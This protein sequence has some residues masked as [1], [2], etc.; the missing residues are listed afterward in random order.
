MNGDYIE[1]KIGKLFNLGYT[2]VHEAENFLIIPRIVPMPLYPD[3]E[4][5]RLFSE[6]T[7]FKILISGCKEYILLLYL[8]A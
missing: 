7:G 3:N 6:E 8:E 2:E 1:K 5:L 4:I